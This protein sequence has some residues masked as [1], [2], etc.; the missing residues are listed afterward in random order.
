MIGSL[1]QIDPHFRECSEEKTYALQ[2]MGQLSGHFCEEVLVTIWHAEVT[3]FKAEGSLEPY[4]MPLLLLLL[5][6]LS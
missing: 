4:K 6:P 5:M 2:Y 3:V 1:K